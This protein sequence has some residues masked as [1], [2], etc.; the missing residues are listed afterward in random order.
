MEVAFLDLI[1]LSPRRPKPEDL[2]VWI[3]YPGIKPAMDN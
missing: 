2:D 3:T 1:K